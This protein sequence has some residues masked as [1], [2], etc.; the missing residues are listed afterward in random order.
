MLSANAWVRCLCYRRAYYNKGIQS[1]RYSNGFVMSRNNAHTG[2]R[3]G[4]CSSLPAYET[5]ECHMDGETNGGQQE[6]RAQ[7]AAQTNG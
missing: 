2:N 5:K 6:T 1:R 7:R 3:C 4:H